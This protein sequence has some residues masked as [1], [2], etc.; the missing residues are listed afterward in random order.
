MNTAVAIVISVARLPL[1]PTNKCNY[2][3]KLL[4]ISSMRFKLKTKKE[5][6]TKMNVHNGPTLSRESQ[7]I[8]WWWQCLRCVNPSIGRI[9]SH[10][11]TLYQKLFSRNKINTFCVAQNHKQPWFVSQWNILE[12]KSSNL[13]ESSMVS[14]NDSWKRASARKLKDIRSRW[15]WSLK[16]IRLDASPKA[17][18]LS[19]EAIFS[20]TKRSMETMDTHFQTQ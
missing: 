16:G 19:N 9:K 4:W 2:E 17:I 20:P 12:T 1:L 8:E 10:K 15:T 14:W 7:S 13:N 11:I 18:Y 3:S 5:N 6:I